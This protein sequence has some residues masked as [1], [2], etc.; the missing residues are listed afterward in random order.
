VAIK[1]FGDYFSSG[2]SNHNSQRPVLDA[3]GAFKFALIARRTDLRKLI[4]RVTNGMVGRD[5]CDSDQQSVIFTDCRATDSVRFIASYSTKSG[6]RYKL[7]SSDSIISARKAPSQ[8][9]A[10]SKRAWRTMVP[11]MNATGR[12]H[13]PK[14]SGSQLRRCPFWLSAQSRLA[15]PARPRQRLIVMFTPNGTIP[16][17]FWPEE[18]GADFTL[19]EILTRSR[20][21]R[22]ACSF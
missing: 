5:E 4:H 3:A 7:A 16:P 1:G 19:K 11:A 21:L 6:T 20:R 15:S 18:T 17:S 8:F 10:L 22:A 12:R 13:F 2:V 14:Q 9:R